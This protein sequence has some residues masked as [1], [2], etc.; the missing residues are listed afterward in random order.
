MVYPCYPKI[1]QSCT[2]AVYSHPLFRWY[3]VVKQHINDEVELCSNTTDTML[4]WLRAEVPWLLEVRLVEVLILLLVAYTHR[5]EAPAAST[6]LT[7]VSLTLL[8]SDWLRRLIWRSNNSRAI[9]RG[10]IYGASLGHAITQ[11]ISRE[12]LTDQSVRKSMWDFWWL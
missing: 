2:A 5:P 6:G 11:A 12:L 4:L 1:R 8:R 9:W 10:S 7:W 3:N